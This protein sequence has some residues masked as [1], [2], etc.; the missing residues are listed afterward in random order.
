[1]NNISAVVLTKNEENNLE[2]CLNSLNWCDEIV[3]VEDNSSDNTLKIA[4]KFTSKIFKRKLEKD[5]ASQR[6]FGLSKVKTKWTIFVDADETVSKELA[7]EIKNKI[8]KTDCAGFYL[9]RVDKFREKE[10]KGGEWGN[11]RLLRLAKTEE[12][13]WER[14]VHET[15]RV[16]G[17]I[18]QLKNPL[19]HS[20][21]QDIFEFV[22]HIKN[23][24]KIHAT[25]NKKEGK[26]SSLFRIILSPILKFKVN[27][28]LKMGFKDGSIGFIYAILMSFHSF[29]S[30]SEL[31]LIQN[32][33][34]ED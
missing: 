24:S 17:K 23:Y 2:K 18:G 32:K 33:S 5:F 28:F 11:Q 27:Y 15:W 31:W 25:E 7:E 8:V 26:T 6:N 19:Y 34:K 16:G 20:P 4:Q 30:W 14:A 12:G 22:D 13:K 10:L 21:H 29:L 9:N 1:M 3:V